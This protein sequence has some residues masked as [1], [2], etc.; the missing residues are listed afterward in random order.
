MYNCSSLSEITIPE[1]VTSIGDYAFNGCSNLTEVIIPVGVT[2]IG[3]FTFCGCVSLTEVT[4]PEDVTSIG[5]YAFYE[6]RN[7]TEITIPESVTSIG[8]CAFYNCD[9]LTQIILPSCSVS[10]SAFGYCDNVGIIIVDGDVEIISGNPFVGCSSLNSVQVTANVD[11]LKY[12]LL[13]CIGGVGSGITELTFKGPNEFVYFGN[14]YTVVDLTL[15]PNGYSVDSDGNLSVSDFLAFSG[16]CGENVSWELYSNGLLKII[17]SGDMTD[18]QHNTYY[19]YYHNPAPWYSYKSLIKKVTIDEGVTKIG[20]YTFAD[21]TSLT[22]ISIPAS[23]ISIGSYTFNNCNNLTGV[24]IPESVTSIG[25]YAFQKCIGLTEMTIPECVTTIGGS[26]FSGCSGLTKISLPVCTLGDDSVLNGCNNLTDISIIVT[27]SVDILTY[28]WLSKFGSVGNGITELIFR[29]PNEFMYAGDDYTKGELTL[30]A[31]GYSVDSDGNLTVNN[32]IVDSGTCG[33]NATWDFY[34]NGLIKIIG[35]GDM[36]DYTYSSMPWYNSTSF[37]RKVEIEEGITKIGSYAFYNCSNLTD[38]TISDSVTFIGSNSFSY[39]SKLTKI[40]IPEDVTFIGSY[41]LSGCK[42]LTEIIIPEGVTTINYNTFYNCSGLISVSIPDSVTSIGSEAF[43]NCDGLTEVSVPSC[44][45]SSKAFGSCNNLS[46]VI[47]DGDIT[48][49]SS[50]TFSGCTL[51][52]SVTVTS[53]VDNL[54]YDILN[55]IGSASGGIADL[56]FEG[57]NEFLYSGENYTVGDLTLAQNGYSVDADGNLSV[58]EKYLAYSGSC[59]T[60]VTWKLYSNGLLEII[61]SGNMYDYSSGSTPWYE[62]SSFISEVVIE[63]GITSVGQNAFYN[64]SSIT[65][66]TLPESVTYIGSYAFQNCSSLTDVT[67][68]GGVTSINYRTFSG[69]T[70]MTQV[71]ISD[72]VTS[73]SDYAFQNCDSLTQITLPSCS[74]SYYAFS[75]CDKLNRVVIDGNISLDSNAFIGCTALNS[76]TV[77]ANVDKLSYGILN[78]IGNAS[79]GITEILFEGPNEFTYSGNDY[80]VGDLTLAQNEYSV[81]SN[82]ELTIL[83][84]ILYSDYCGYNAIWELYSNGLLKIKGSGDI[85]DCSYRGGAPWNQ[86]KSLVKEVVV[87][88]GITSI[89]DYAFYN[90]TNLSKATI[91]E[92]VTSIG[93]SAFY[94]CSSLSEIIIPE[95]V[96][97]I[98]S[99]VFSDCSSLSAV[100][101]P[102]GVTSIGNSAF[103]GCSSLSEITIPESVTSIG[104]YAFCDCSSLTEITIPKGVTSIGSNVFSDCNSLTAIHVDENNQY[105]ASVEGVLF[106]KSLTQLIRYPLD[107]PDTNYDVPSGVLQIGYSAFSYCNNLESVTIPDGVTEIDDSTFYNCNN[108]ID[109]TIPEGITSI[110]S[111]AFSYCNSLTGIVIPESLTSIGSSA[112]SNC[113]GLTGITIPGSVISIGGG[114]FYECNNLTEIIIN[115]GV[116]SIGSTAFYDC[117]KLTNI[118]LPGSVTSIGDSAF[119]YCSSLKELELPDGI[120]QIGEHTF[121]Y[122]TS[123]E[124]VTIPKSVKYIYD[125]AFYKCSKL[126]E[127]I[128][129]SCSI[130]DSSFG[131]C[132][133]LSHVIIDGNVTTSY[134]YTSS[135]AFSGCYSVESVTVT[136][137]VD[138]LSCDVLDSID[139]VSGITTIT[140]EGPN[141]FMFENGEI[142]IGDL[143]LEYGEYYVDENNVL[144]KVESF[145]YT[146]ENG[147]VY[148]IVP[149]YKTASLDEFPSSSDISVFE[150]P[151]TLTLMNGDEEITVTVTSIGDR[152]FYNCTGLAEITIPNN[153][154]SIGDFAFYNCDGLKEITLPS[155]VLQWYAFESC[156]NLSKVTIDGNVTLDSSS[157]FSGCKSLKSVTVTANVDVLNYDLLDRMGSSSGGITSVTFEG[158]NT[159]LY[160]GSDY[161][162]GKLTLSAGAYDVD[163]YGN[164]SISSESFLV[165]SGTCGTRIIWEVYSNGLLKMYGSGDMEGNAYGAS[166]LPWY[167]YRS[168]IKE[169]VIEEGITSICYSAFSGY[170]GLT[171]VTIPE[172][173][174][175]ISNSAFSGCTGL[176]EIRLPDS[177]TSIGSYA[178]QNCSNLTEIAIPDCVTSIGQYAFYNC[179]R[180]TKVA[181]PAG[182]TKI[183][184]STFYGCTS[185]VDL[186]ISE[187]VTSIGGNSFYKCNSLTKVTIPNSVKSIGDSAF[188]DCNNLIELYLPSCSISQNAFSSCDKLAHVIIDGQPSLNPSAFNGCRSLKSVTITANVDKLSYDSLYYIGNASGGLTIITFEGPNEFWY[189]GDDYTIGD[190]TLTMG[191]YKVDEDGNLSRAEESVLYSGLCGANA[192]WELWTNGLLK[193]TGSGAMKNY[194]YSSD[195]PWYKH[196]SYI[197]NLEIEEGITSIGNYAFSSCTDFT[198]ATIPESVM[199]IGDSAFSGCTGLTEITIV[200]GVTTL[201]NYVFSGCTG[202]AEV[203]MPESLISIGSSAFYNCTGLKNVTIPS[204]VTTIANSAFYNC[205]G[206]KN[207]TIPSGITTIAN[208]AFYGCTGLV[209]VVISEGVTSIGDSAFYC[210]SLAKVTIPESIIS[211]GDYAFYCCSLTE[212]KI[213]E[214]ITLI[215]EGVFAGCTSMTQVIIPDSVTSIG[216]QAFLECTSLTNLTIP[217]S[218]TFIDTYAFAGCNALTEVILPGCTLSYGIFEYCDNLCKIIIDGDVELDS[219]GDT[220]GC[221]SLESLTVSAKV[222]TLTS[223]VLEYWEVGGI[224]EVAFEGINTF[225]YSGSDITVNDITLSEGDYYVDENGNLHRVEIIT[226]TDECGVEYE[227]IPEQGIA[228]LLSFPDSSDIGI[229]DIPA[230]L[231]LEYNDEEIT[232]DIVFVGDSAFSGCTGL[233]EVTIPDSVITIGD[234]AFYGCTGLTEVTIPES[235]T[236]IGDSAFSGCTGLTEVTIPESVITIGDSAFYGCTGLTEVTLPGCTVNSNAFYDCDGLTK[237]TVNGDIALGLPNPFAECDSIESITVTANVNTLYYELFAAASEYGE[238]ITEI[239]FEGPNE[240]MYL[241]E[242]YTIGDLTLT[243]G[244]YSIDENGNL[245][246]IEA[247][248]LYSGTCGE[249]AEWE[250]WSNGLLKIKGSGCMEYY[251]SESTPWYEYRTLIYKIDIEDG[252]TEISDYA[253]ADC[254]SL[255]DVVIPANAYIGYYAFANCSSLKEVTLPSC[256]LLGH[257]VFNNCNSLTNLIVDGYVYARGGDIFYGCSSLSSVTVTDNVDKLS[258]GL[259]NNIGSASVGLTEITFEGP[260]SFVLYGDLTVGDLELTDGEYYVDADGVLHKIE[261]IEHTDENG[262]VYELKSI[263]NTATLITYPT[264]LTDSTFTIPET[265]VSDAGDEYIV[266]AIGPSAFRKCDNLMEL[267][268]PDSV[269]LIGSYAFQNCSGLTNITI[270][271]GVTSI[272]SYAFSGCTALTEITLP[273]SLTSI[274]SNTFYNC[275]KL[276]EI[277]LP[278][279]LTSI[280]SYAFQNCT[281][282]TDITIPDG[283]TAINYN[284]FSGCSKLTSVTIPDSVTSIGTDAFYNCD[285][286]T[287]ISLPSCSI[288]SYAF[289]SCNNLSRV[290]IDG[291]V[292]LSSSSQFYGCTSL[293]SAIVTSNVDTLN[294]TLL[295]NMGSA[296][297]GITEITFEG[298][299]TFKY[300]GSDKTVSGLTLTE[301]DYYVDEYG[302]LYRLNDDDMTAFLVKYPEASDSDSYD[303]PETIEVD[304]AVYTVTG[305]ETYAFS[306]NANLQSVNIPTTVTELGNGVF[307]NCTNLVMVN[308]YILLDEVI[309]SL[310]HAGADFSMFFNTPL[311][312]NRESAAVTIENIVID[313]DDGNVITLV[314]EDTE[315]LTGEKV[316]S[317][318]KISRGADSD[319]VITRVY[320]RFANEHSF[321][322]YNNDDLNFSG[323]AA[324]VVKS[325]IPNVYYFEIQ[326]VPQG[327]QLNFDVYYAYKNLLSGGG[328]AMIWISALTVDEAQALGDSLTFPEK[329]H[330]VTWTTNPET[331]TLGDSGMSSLRQKDLLGNGTEEGSILLKSAITIPVNITSNDSAYADI[332]TDI[333]KSVDFVTTFKLP[334][335]FSWTEGILESIIAGDYRYS[336]GTIEVLLNGKYEDLFYIT[337]YSYVNNF[338]LSVDDENNIQFSWTYKNSSTAS[339]I[340]DR[341]FVITCYENHIEADVSSLTETKHPSTGKSIYGYDFE[342][343]NKAT[344]NYSFSES[345]TLS[346]EY[347]NKC[348]TNTKSLSLSTNVTSSTKDLGTTYSIDGYIYMKTNGYYYGDEYT[349]DFAVTNNGPS[350]IDDVDYLNA[351]LDTDLYIKPEQME[352]MFMDYGKDLK[353]SIDSATLYN[354]REL[355][356][357]GI[358]GETYTID[359]EQCGAV[360]ASYHGSSISGDVRSS[361]VHMEITLSDDGTHFI[362]KVGNSATYSIGTG[363]DYESIADAFDA[364]GYI[365]TSSAKYTYTWDG[366]DIDLFSGEKYTFKIISTIKDSFMRGDSFGGDC[367]RKEIYIYRIV[368]AYLTDDEFSAGKGYL[369]D[370]YCV[371]NISLSTEISPDGDK[372]D[373]S[374][375]SENGG[376]LSH[377]ICVRGEGTPEYDVLPLVEQIEDR[378]HLL[379][380]VAENS[381]NPSLAGLELEVVEVEGVS[382]Y[383]LDVLGTYENLVIGDIVADRVVMQVYDNKTESEEDD[384]IET[385]I[386]WYL[387]DVDQ[388]YSRNVKFKTIVDTDLSGIQLTKS[389]I[390]YDSKAWLN[391][392]QNHRLYYNTSEQ[393]DLVDIEKFILNDTASDPSFGTT[394]STVKDGDSVTYCIRIDNLANQPL[395]INGQYINDKLPKIPNNYW[396][397]ENIKVEYLPTAGYELTVTGEDSW[398]IYNESTTQ[399]YI[400]WNSD[401]TF[402]FTGAFYIR[403]TLD[404]P[405]GNAWDEYCNTYGDSSVTSMTT[406]LDLTDSVQHT[407]LVSGEFALHS[408]VYRTGIM[409][410][411]TYLSY[412][413]SEGLN[414]YTNDGM[415]DGIVTYYFTIYNSGYSKLYLSDVQAILPEGFTY[416]GLY[417]NSNTSY[418]NNYVTVSDPDNK[419]V[420]YRNLSIST[421][422]TNNDG[423]KTYTPDGNQIV[424][425]VIG[426]R[427]GG[428]PTSYLEHGQ[429]VTVAFNCYTNN[430]GGSAD[431]APCTI[432]MPYYDYIGGGARLD[433]EVTVVHKDSDGYTRKAN[434][435][436]RDVL[437]DNEAGMTGVNTDTVYATDG[438]FTSTVSVRKATDI[439]LGIKNDCTVAHAAY[440]DTIKWQITSKNSGSGIM[441]DYTVTDV[442]MKPYTFFGPVGYKVYNSDSAYYAYNDEMFS[443]SEHNTESDT[444]TIQPPSGYGSGKTLTLSK[445]GD[446][447]EIDTFLR[448]SKNG[449]TV[450]ITV[451]VTLSLDENGNEVLSVTFPNDTASYASIPANGYSVLEVGT[452]N[453]ASEQKNT[454]YINNAYLTPAKD[455]KFNVEAGVSSVEYNGKSSVTDDDNVYVT[456]GYYMASNVSVEELDGSG[457]SAKGSDSTN[458]IILSDEENEF[459]YTFEVY[460]W[461]GYNSTAINDID[462]LVMIG[463]LPDV[464][465]HSPLYTDFK[466]HSEFRVNFA[467]DPDFSVWITSEDA[468]T[469]EVDPQY[470]TIMFSESTE[471]TSEDWDGTGSDGWYTLDQVKANPD[472]NIRSVRI[473]ITE[474]SGALMPNGATIGVSFNAVGDGSQDPGEIAWNSFGY[475]YSLVGDDTESVVMPEKVGVMIAP[476][477]QIKN[478]L[479]R[480]RGGSFAA[481]SDVTFKYVIYNASLLEFPADYT[482]SDIIEELYNAGVSFTVLELTVNEGESVAKLKL[483]DLYCYTYVNGEAVATDEKFDWVNN[484]EY[485]VYQLPKDGINIYE[486]AYFNGAHPNN[487]TFTY[488]ETD[489]LDI[490]STNVRIEWTIQ[491][492]MEE[493]GTENKLSD[494]F[495]GL[496]SLKRS[497]L[498]SDEAYEAMTKSFKYAPNK[499]VT[500]DSQTWYLADIKA[501]DENG[502]LQ[503]SELLDLNWYIEELKAPDGYNLNPDAHEILTYEG[504]KTESRTYASTSSYELPMTGGMGTTVYYVAGVAVLVVG[505]VVLHKKRKRY[506][507]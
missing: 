449:S 295:Y 470:Y 159:F 113:T 490:T 48:L 77:T 281:G 386:F 284:T 290:I 260:N 319:E 33:D 317:S 13:N 486:F 70:G 436:D 57:P 406:V 126:T 231:T 245:S 152:A 129:P 387:L 175:T 225:T 230:P 4:I 476:V 82:G 489:V 35:S 485:T 404:F 237:I 353:I 71:I 182:V 275:S 474:E 115:E 205:T 43:Y 451:T 457:E 137:N 448:Y 161:T 296:S 15:S 427:S 183:D 501:T 277:I 170:T 376:I 426:S 132:S 21:C 207:V 381:D 150:I 215:G 261:V 316:K 47:I 243:M 98:G 253:F 289:E 61:G 336:Y 76:V 393:Y 419:N 8:E 345:K 402:T 320:I 378:Q 144:H 62:Y 90:C 288:S 408:G 146:D 299:N 269:T 456:Y 484:S 254:T 53:N 200:E 507:N 322:E 409:S 162:V 116:A 364:I 34:S 160:L 125:N 309:E 498:M 188:Y 204:G 158:P 177:I 167:Q 20:N 441:R 168:L 246:I 109:V 100:T 240:F 58:A 85:D 187:G 450:R 271:E 121:Y 27:D 212:V 190:L 133:K 41:A 283:V 369:Y 504:S 234:S 424:T 349:Y 354:K 171:E 169:V 343:R 127:I 36:Y 5:T 258:S 222:D 466:R 67:I 233:T 468:E 298:P 179:S 25:S 95:S 131:N 411:G 285:A 377:D 352:A 304:G 437:T 444:V 374:V 499:V 366:E 104:D 199:V 238:G 30:T 422:T 329:I 106:N 92:G 96:T 482:E 334:E 202:L 214:S 60:N 383:V 88:E 120:K 74:V 186:T 350:L 360:N 365:V 390:E 328:D 227:V 156:D 357:T 280:G 412:K 407:L 410:Q 392:H 87:E 45:I 110:G 151:E 324:K 101:I 256:Y 431:I 56:T 344:V 473:V 367:I 306:N 423:T 174:T 229:F 184:N 401:C 469:A 117:N 429:A 191:N 506:S 201:G 147:V 178:F 24:T 78:N 122:C 491:V 265:V 330:M 440:V 22:E 400:K 247:T 286:L 163:E 425:F 439:T 176:T 28:G 84:S 418:Y 492:F 500:V 270:T 303:V 244:N 305:I 368:N 347:V 39:C 228:V 442:M 40:T 472:L 475:R 46:R 326:P 192:K 430:E 287:E 438:W 338:K 341:S 302:V 332:G 213:P 346:S 325:T 66:L 337:N 105:Y 432:I 224:N 297:G 420:S 480:V 139:R 494:A 197:R 359:E 252:I 223:D 358:D 391:D 103:Y 398:Y 216:S 273:D 361:N 460:N 433:T 50:N 314:T 455:Q 257:A 17:G 14:E 447:A 64:C 443:I 502:A 145:E 266:V 459:R 138:R 300:T 2:S 143:T 208:S 478:E 488:D 454:L 173:V 263:L 89:G 355:E 321:V 445:D 226:F 403:I 49:S 465:D 382:Y 371:D 68:P 99:G 471:Y 3:G 405:T 193:I 413:N 130:S 415:D 340:S 141:S 194:T 128:L 259:L 241:G 331:F 262:I 311:W 220:A 453:F 363:Y 72:N 189:T 274:S 31:N 414:H 93:N 135:N 333:V 203:T 108:L 219:P 384:E 348:Y 301:G 327:E 1:V 111:S 251:D 118:I 119:M 94:G 375:L 496:Y 312:L 166:Y 164:L 416:K 428:V 282:L 218:V 464:G 210:C 248:V 112:F 396:N 308:G 102:E 417:S 86:Y 249:D 7:L 323:T 37:V 185:L 63:D 267:T 107:K 18:Y 80:T 136:A 154:T 379:I 79:G 481:E 124:K 9:S 279:N 44:S 51:L 140:F 165:D 19:P 83:I 385:L 42:V 149:I 195:V 134:D 123:L 73:I 493:L 32:Y 421:K 477:P 397:E 148:E 29:G 264:T 157:Q 310:S 497:K 6:C 69:C 97:S 278:D 65:D 380:P 196:T 255:Y 458:Y 294:Y 372:N 209:D 181:I 242:D 23:V 142:T 463:N 313:N 395:S 389:Y 11:S 483:D 487:Y 75:H 339:E 452:R 292:T 370:Q 318:V 250:L 356:V 239:S 435:G 91:A 503:W 268:I 81:D 26:A 335:H 172:S 479:I 307:E 38:V 495:F 59:G 272:G 206:L 114:A 236:T 217:K 12:D 235:V 388:S 180:L 351:P 505:A 153:V 315:A 211:I 462:K 221:Y 10:N 373:Y 155:C 446:S 232:A 16:S 399:Q 461:D 394:E 362:L 276:T 467:D 55:N 54:S 293:K 291:N 198:V 52:N 434:S 342:I